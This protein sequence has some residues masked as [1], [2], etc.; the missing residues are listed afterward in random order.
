MAYKYC[1]TFSSQWNIPEEGDL[2]LKA[3]TVVLNDDDLGEHE[4][5]EEVED[6]DGEGGEV[7]VDED[8]DLLL[9]GLVQLQQEE[10]NNAT[11]NYTMSFTPLN[12]KMKVCK[13]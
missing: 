5:D 13:F 6:G 1:Q 10:D 11:S 12:S 2:Q 7:L 4:G 9:S 8:H 3:A